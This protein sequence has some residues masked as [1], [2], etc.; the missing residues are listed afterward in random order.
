[1]PALGELYDTA[2]ARLSQVPGALRAGL[3]TS[4][5]AALAADLDRFLTRLQASFGGTEPTRAIVASDLTAHLAMAQ[6]E[7]R[8]ALRLLPEPSPTDAG[9]ARMLFTEATHAVSA[10]RD[11]IESHRS[12]DRMPLTP[13]AYHFSSQPALDY[14]T[15]RTAD[16]AWQ[17]G[18]ISHELTQGMMH[19][20]VADA[21][22]NARRY[23]DQAA[24]FGRAG[25][26]NTDPA[27]A[28]F[29]LALP[30]EPVQV[31]ADPTHRL[32]AGL[33]DDCERLSRASFEVLH[34]RTDHRL[35]GSDVQHLSRWAAM[36]RLLSGRL[37][38]RVADQHP[39]APTAEALRS[40]AGHL[41]DAAQAWQ[42]AAA[43]WR[44]IVDVAD[45]RAHPKLPPPS[46]EI[47][48]RGQVVQLPQVVPHPAAVI[49][50]T[51]VTRLGKLLYGPQWSPDGVARGPGQPRPAGEI[52]TD[53][54][55]EGRLAATL[56]RLPATGRQLALAA[57]AAIQ[58]A[59]SGLVTDSPEHRPP[60]LDRGIHWYPIHEHQ[61][62]PL[63]V[64]YEAVGRAEE[65]AA[66]SLLRVAENAGTAVPRALLDIAAYRQL[67]AGPGEQGTP[68]RARVRQQERAAAAKSRSTGYHV[69][70]AAVS[71]GPKTDDS[72]AVGPRKELPEHRRGTHTSR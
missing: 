26:R 61:A 72:A 44:R 18:Q 23:L 48:R 57:P 52:L 58:R 63:C 37:L 49:M 70:P 54:R 21:L 39:D 59:K 7:V 17:A 22:T 55:G 71:L 45:P 40:A 35:S 8:T 43:K 1:M 50:H 66:A 16:L 30:V 31:G 27:A 65:A 53:T 60:G 33:E 29:P 5:R 28:A 47:V 6:T 15:R 9:R 19:P 51:S 24:V 68:D 56:Y 3:D 2:D 10:V 42:G 34:D 11:V 36:G 13:Y 32:P 67:A 25:T 4:Q 64:A 38:L 41:R 46:Y 20:G 69:L 62:E 12:V 14:L